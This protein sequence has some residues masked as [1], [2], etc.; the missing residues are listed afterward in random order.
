MPAPSFALRRPG[1]G[2]WQI[3]PL[4]VFLLVAF[5]VPVGVILSLAVWTPG[6]GF[7]GTAL[8]RILGTPVYRTVLGRTLEIAFWTTAFCLVGGYPIAAWIQRLRGAPR[9]V[10]YVLV[11]LPFWTSFLIKAFAWLVLL[12]R[13]GAVHALLAAVGA[14]SGQSFLFSLPAVLVGMVHA[15]LPFAVLTILPV[16]EGLDPRLPQAAGALGARPFETFLRVRLPLAAPGIAAAMLIVFV[17]ALGFFIVPALLGGP[18]QTM[19]SNVVIELVQELLDWPLA[20][21]ASL[22]VFAVVALLFALYVRS[23]GIETLV[24][25]ARVAREGRRARTASPSLAALRARGWRVVD[26]CA[27]GLA[28]IDARWPGARAV[29]RWSAGAAL[30]ALLAF[31]ALPALF[32]VPVSF[33]TSGII[34]WPPQFLSLRWYAALDTP[35]WRAAALR[36]LLAATA[37]GVLSL[38]LAVPAALWFVRHARGLRAA[39]LVAM[40]APMVLPRIIIAMGLFYLF[41]RLGLVGSTAGLVVGHTVIALPFVV[42]TLIAVV[43]N[44]DERLDQAAEVCGAT[45]WLRWRRVTLPLLMPGLVAGF[46]FAFVTSLDEL[47]IALFVT[48]GL[49]STLP[50]QMWDEALLRISPTLAAASTVLFVFMSA[51]VLAAQSLRQRRPSRA[52]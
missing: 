17:T 29:R 25:R 18:R 9:Q 32:L 21:A 28:R 47:T 51:A 42:T 23:F 13:N 24:G 33:T 38:A 39:A 22:L 7:S 3:A 34:D 26:A 14:P 12:G 11:L 8:A 10:V 37:T 46:L 30:I 27:A 4:A 19:I 36:S 2:T 52:A 41:A 50:K 15:L 45:P 44:Y 35:I 5:F 40:I 16:L 43:Q 20:A 1:P 48:G 49:S 31:L 6:H